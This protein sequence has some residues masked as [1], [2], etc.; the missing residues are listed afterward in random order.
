[1][2]TH[3][4]GKVKDKYKPSKR[5]KYYL[6]EMMVIENSLK[7]IQIAE[8]MKDKEFLFVSSNEE[9]NNLLK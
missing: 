6:L 3:L 9:I 8:I 5:K 7:A 2:L 1:M 4:F